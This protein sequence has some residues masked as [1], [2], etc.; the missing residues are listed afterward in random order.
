MQIQP[1]K[2]PVPQPVIVTFMTRQTLAMMSSVCITSPRPQVPDACR[3]LTFQSVAKGPRDPMFD[4]KKAADENTSP[5]KVDLG[6][7]VYRNEAGAYHEFP[8]V[9]EVRDRS[10]ENWTIQQISN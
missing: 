7:G 6:A 8:A 3:A 10:V 5:L 9:K 1:A 2:S 4:L